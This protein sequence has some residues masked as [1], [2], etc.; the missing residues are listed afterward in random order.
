MSIKTPYIVLKITLNRYNIVIGRCTNKT[1]K[2]FVVIILNPN[3]RKS[4]AIGSRGQ[5]FESKCVK[6]VFV[7]GPIGIII[8]PS[9]KKQ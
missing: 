2:R 3:L 9:S 7:G 1:F 5:G 6:S 8:I 4:F